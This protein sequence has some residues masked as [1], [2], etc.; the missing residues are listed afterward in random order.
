MV[1]SLKSNYNDNIDMV[2][3]YKYNWCIIRAVIVV[4]FAKWCS[5]VVF[6][7][8]CKAIRTMNSM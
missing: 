1:G 6:V 3:I 7:E 2:Y 5:D 4:L 8:T